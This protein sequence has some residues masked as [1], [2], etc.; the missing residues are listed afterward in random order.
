[1]ARCRDLRKRDMPVTSAKIRLSDLA[2]CVSQLCRSLAQTR[3]IAGFAL[4]CGV[5]VC[6]YMG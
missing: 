5:F 4:E 6:L 2:V 1:M 3:R